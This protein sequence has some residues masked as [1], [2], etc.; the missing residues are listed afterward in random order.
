MTLKVFFI[1]KICRTILSNYLS[2]KTTT[3]VALFAILFLVSPSLFSQ[4][5][6]VPFTFKV[7]SASKVSAGVF[8]RDGTLVRT[9][10][11][12]VSYTAGTHTANWDR[13]DDEGRLV[14]DTG[15]VVKVISSNVNYKWEGVIGNTSDSLTGPTVIRMFERMHGLA[16]AGFNA[17]YGAGYTEGITSSYKFNTK[18]PQKKYNILYSEYQDMAQASDYVATDSNYVYWAGYDAFDDNKQSFVY[19]TKVSNDQ[20]VLFANGTSVEVTHGRTYSKAIDV[21]TGDI[22][23]L[24]KGLAVQKKGKYLFVS[25]PGNNELHV[26]NKTTGALVQTLTVTAPMGLAVDKTDALWMIS[27]N[28]DVSKY[29]VNTNGT[30]GTATLTLTGLADPLALAV[31]PDGKIIVVIDGGS[32]Q[33]VKAFNNST[34]VSAWTLGQK[35]GY[36]T[37]PAVTDDKFYFSD[38]VTML[39]H[40]FIAFQQDGS[41]WLGDVGNERVQHYN[42]SRVYIDRIMSLPHSYSVA[43]DR[44][45]PGR[46][47][48]EYLEFKVDYTKSLG[49]TNGSW[50]LVRNWRR[51]VKKDYFQEGMMRIFNQVI[52]LSNGRTY[53]TLENCYV[54]DERYPEIVELPSSGNLRYTGVRFDVDAKD[55]IQD[56]GSR[57][58]YISSGHIGDVGIWETQKLTGFTN[59]NPV[60][61]TTSKIGSTP[62][63]AV[64]DPASGY[65]IDPVLTSS[66]MLIT[67]DKD[68][69]NQGF[70][71]GAIKK[72]D[73]K[74]LWKTSPSTSRDYVGPFPTDGAFDIGNNV[75]YS[76]GHAYSMERSILWNY[77]GEFWKNS[78]TNIWNHF[79]DNG[80]MVGQF[81]VAL[82]DA[83]K[84]TPEAY[85]MGA[86]NVF[87][88]AVVKV[89]NDYYIYHNDESV[90][91]GVH[92][93]KITGLNTINEVSIPVYPQAAISGGLVGT[94]F[95]GAELNNMKIV[96][97]VVDQTVNMSTP[98]SKLA[99]SLS[100]STRWT[101]FVKPAYSQKYTFYTNTSKGVRLWI[102]GQL[103]I[104]KWSNGSLFENSG[105]ITLESGKLYTVKMEIN[106]GVAALSWSSS[107]QSKQVIPSNNLYPSEITDYSG[108]IDLMEGLHFK[109]VLTDGMYG[110]KRNPVNE[111]STSGEQYW[112]VQTG[113]QSFKKDRPDLYMTFRRDNGAYEVTRDLGT[114]ATCIGSW[115]LNGSISYD[116]NYPKWT[117]DDGGGYFEVLDNQGKVISRITQEQYMSNGQMY[118]M[119]KCNGKT[120]HDMMDRYTYIFSNK[121]QPFELTVSSAGIT[122]KYGTFA[123]VDAA[124]FDAKSNWNKPSSIRF[125]FIGTTSSY[126]RVINIH[127]LSMSTDVSTIPEVSASGPVTF[128]KGGS[129]VLTASSASSYL[130]NNNATTQSI[131]VSS[132]GSYSVTIKDA[133]GCAL[134]TKP[135]DVIVNALPVP[136]IKA[137]ATSFCTGDSV[138]LSSDSANDYLWNNGA[139]SRSIGVKSAGNYSVKV[140]DNNGCSG[141]SAPLA[142]SE[143][144][145]PTAT[146][147]ANGP[148]SFCSGKSVTLT[149]A[150]ASSYLWNTKETTQSITV[151][152]PGDYSVKTSD[153]NGCFSAYSAPVSI[154]VSYIADPSISVS[155]PTSFCVG[156]STVLTASTASAYHWSTN[157]TTQSITVYTSGDYSVKVSDANGC[158]SQYS[159]PVNIQAT[160]IS[161]P[162]VA[163][164]GLT[165]FCFGN[166]ALLTASPAKS[167]LW[168]TGETTQSITVK[169]SGN[170]QV[171]ITDENGCS[172]PSSAVVVT[173][174]PIPEP[175]VSVANDSLLTS[176]AQKGN[177]WFLNGQPIKGATTKY[178][179]A[180]ISGDY[181]VVVTENDCQG[182][183]PVVA[184]KVN[185]PGNGT[186]ISAIRQSAFHIYPNPSTGLIHFSG[187]QLTGAQIVITNVKGQEVYSGIF[188]VGDI[189]LSYQA[190]GLYIVTVF[191]G[192][193]KSVQKLILH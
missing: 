141:S 176:T 40:P 9:L 119:L 129:V 28:G 121:P 102:D 184:V 82:L 20:E 42:S 122:F 173:V 110:W 37:D 46:V 1:T 135:L 137:A 181:H 88:S 74:Y 25:H 191:S 142:I 95:N 11:N 56:D 153:K 156:K 59:N 151:T 134:S 113:V 149:V 144:S 93:W 45:D 188:N 138:I 182:T 140:T 172:A 124:I 66:D 33:Q 49:A 101:G 60:W 150:S 7:N 32:S 157:E 92:R 133:N 51:G 99:N 177:Q 108:N 27:G 115:K 69:N 114:P 72:G 165:S 54:P 15:F 90:H 91:A 167:Y 143:N 35:G 48:N 128:C 97:A 78:Q 154:S 185:K 87:S 76:G 53:A 10:W 166:S 158:A 67:F 18:D 112:H 80:L 26:L 21:T 31:S 127:S 136:V 36:E 104:N 19:A 3:F 130:W 64:N 61:G 190:K 38:D 132:A 179:I 4:N 105:S 22:N 106:G 70:H 63:I 174:N 192:Q 65:V 52:T 163:V 189:D 55:L 24:P 155:G 162:T 71:L 13:K 29:P 94:W 96:S 8:K 57:I 139:V 43:V 175:T 171:A 180:H 98:S 147:S 187:E 75:E 148:T 168:S 47:F 2:R 17:Y 111:D 159:A 103:I 77:H 193:E 100:F 89:G 86:G 30:L 14:A 81:G 117:D 83:E 146:A 73:N 183:S 23:A 5:A 178:Y 120:I 34:G 116:G 186:G 126:D 131:T 152:E 161:T 50:T 41:F 118:I 123:A 58:R 164:T 145:L 125:N 12:N 160:S 62:T 79:Y 85:P 16:I 44:N 169:T 109:S 84:I 170:Y 6:L 68:R 39:S 107:S